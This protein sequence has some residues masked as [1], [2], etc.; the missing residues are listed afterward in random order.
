MAKRLGWT[1]DQLLIALRLYMRS[2]FGRLHG[3]NPEIIE[4]AGKIEKT[5][6]ALAMKACNF[7]SFDPVFLASNRK[8]L[9]GASES[10]RAIWH[11]FELNPE[12]LA[13]ETEEAFARLE[14]DAAAIE[15]DQLRVPTGDTD[16]VRMIR[17]RRVQSF[18]RAAVLTSY[19][20]RCAISGLALPD[21]LIASHIVPWSV[22]VE[23]RADP[24]N[25]ICFNALFDRAFDRGFMTLDRDYRVVISSKLHA[26]IQSADLPCSLA[27]AHGRRIRLPTRL[28]PD[29]AALEHHRAHIFLE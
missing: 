19:Q 27:D 20:S 14:P 23:R 17:T 6:N 5:S 13:V 26:A 10:D 15:L 24:R 22:S 18:F 21:L 9:S 25:G 2:S 3:R 8:G 1:R 28:A 7:A 16:V 12:Q 11:E 4:L 29:P